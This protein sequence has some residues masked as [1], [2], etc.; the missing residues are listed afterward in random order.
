MQ[1]QWVAA[2]RFVRL[3]EDAVS[4]PIFPGDDGIVQRMQALMAP[5][6]KSALAAEADLS[7]TRVSQ[8]IAKVQAARR[9]DACATQAPRAALPDRVADDLAQHPGVSGLEPSHSASDRPA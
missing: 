2:G 4:R 7:V 5:A 8:L 1:A 9:G 6:S 3:W